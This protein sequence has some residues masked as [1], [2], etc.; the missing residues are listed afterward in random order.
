MNRDGNIPVLAFYERG[1]KEASRDKYTRLRLQE[2]F[3]IGT[4]AG[5]FMKRPAGPNKVGYSRQVQAYFVTVFRS[6]LFTFQS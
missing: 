5:R 1:V 3:L 4:T 2:H 6:L